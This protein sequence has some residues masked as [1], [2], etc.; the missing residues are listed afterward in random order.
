MG[1]FEISPE[2][3]L[4]ILSTKGWFAERPEPV[5]ALL[6][7]IARVRRFG[8]GEPLYLHGDTANGIFGLADGALDV[9]IPR[10]DGM[11]LSIHRADAG[12]WIGD[13]AFFVGQTR[14]VS[15]VAAI[16]SI[17]V[18]FSQTDLRQLV[19]AAP[20]LIP[21]FYALTYENMATALRLLANLAISSS[22]LRVAVRLLMYEDAPM[23]TGL[24]MSQNKLAEL[25]GLSVPTLQRVLRRMQDE[26]LIKVGY[27]RIQ[28]LDRSALLSKYNTP[29]QF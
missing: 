19:E 11:D 26:K 25:V 22:E 8:A 1:S 16:P 3:A 14:L 18:H 13:L 4:S 17:V 10:A 27:G 20:E 24:A 2:A 15:V 21:E 5:R 23:R 29:S 6:G 28:I 12:F 9:T 7:R